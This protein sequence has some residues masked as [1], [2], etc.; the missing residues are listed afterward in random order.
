MR[1]MSRSKAMANSTRDAMPRPLAP[2]SSDFKYCGV[3]GQNHRNTKTHK[4]AE[5][6][7]HHRAEQP[8]ARAAPPE[9]KAGEKGGKKTGRVRHASGKKR[10]RGKETPETTYTRS[11]PVMSPV[12]LP[13]VTTTVVFV[14]VAGCF[15]D[16]NEHGSENER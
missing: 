5:E 9:E 8:D 14:V 10:R 2:W 7:T 13:P 1:I 15:F 6:G 12:W 3:G 16:D 11:A 4:W